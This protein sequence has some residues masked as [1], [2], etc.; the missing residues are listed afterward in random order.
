VQWLR[1]KMQFFSHAREIE[2]VAASVPDA[3]GVAFVPAFGGLLA[4]HWCPNARG[5]LVGLTQQTTRAHIARA[6]LEAVVH[7]VAELVRLI[8]RDMGDDTVAADHGLNVDG[9]MSANEL[10]M[11]LQA[12]A[13]GVPVRRPSQVETTARGAAMCAAVGAGAVTPDDLTH[14]KLSGFKTFLPQISTEAR[15]AARERWERAV[16]TTVAYAES[17]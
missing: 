12:D 15:A 2:E 10:L 4:P 5:T 16:R 8:Q 7:Q 11:Q 6:T 9:G 13:L 17:H 1:D 3:G 14:A